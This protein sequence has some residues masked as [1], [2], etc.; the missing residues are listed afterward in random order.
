MIIIK[1]NL[2]LLNLSV[3]FFKNLIL[4]SFLEL[5]KKINISNLNE[6]TSNKHGKEVT[7]AETTVLTKD[8]YDLLGVA[9]DV[10][11]GQLR[12]AY[13]LKA[14]KYHPDKNPDDPKAGLIS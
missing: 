2:L 7:M 13:R 10:T 4:I 8:Y 14:L 5:S 6:R 12:K 9:S 3:F 1:I 11:E